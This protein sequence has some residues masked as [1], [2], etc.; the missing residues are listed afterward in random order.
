VTRF[1]CPICNKRAIPLPKGLIGKS[2]VV[3]RVTGGTEI[4]SF[5]THEKCLKRVAHPEYDLFRKDD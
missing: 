5:T 1:V 4:R 3:I 2:T